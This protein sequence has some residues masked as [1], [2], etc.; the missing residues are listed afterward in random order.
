MTVS[1]F[2][3]HTALHH[4]NIVA[5]MAEAV[6]GVWV[7]KIDQRGRKGQRRLKVV[8]DVKRVVDQGFERQVPDM[9]LLWA[10]EED[11]EEDEEEDRG[12]PPAISPAAKQG[13]P[14][15][16]PGAAGQ[17]LLLR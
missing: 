2:P 7:E 3:G 6:G 14:T 10:K 5:Q 17:P 13:V 11:G 4:P 8:C 12:S 16:T 15:R 9:Q 1:S